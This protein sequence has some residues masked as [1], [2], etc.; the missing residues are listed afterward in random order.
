M[1]FK[2]TILLLSSFA[3]LSCVVAPVLVSCSS[4][5]NLSF[6]ENLKNQYLN[7]YESLTNNNWDRNS[8]GSIKDY[9]VTSEQQALALYS[10]CSGTFWNAPLHLRQ[11]PEN[12]LITVKELDPDIPH[13]VNGDG[14]LYLSSAL[15]KATVP[16]DLVVYHGVEFMEVEF[17]NQLKDYIIGNEKDGYDYSNCVNKTITSY[18]FISTS[19]VEAYADCFFDWK[20]RPEVWPNEGIVPNPLKEP[21]LFKIH[22]PKGYVGAAY[23]SNFGFAGFPTTSTEQQVLIDR[24]CKFLITKIDQDIKNSKGD[25]INVF[26]LNLLI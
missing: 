8:D 13:M 9:F 15:Q 20:P 2:R 1:K 14:Y 10:W 22:I 26:E 11:E 6:D 18:G 3:G 5:K 25:L 19:L 24:N 23:L 7:W 17:Y 16:E 12:R 4:N 21:V